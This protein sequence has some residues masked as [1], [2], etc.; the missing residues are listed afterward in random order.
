M[1]STK[2]VF[3]NRMYYYFDDIFKFQ[4]FDFDILLD[5]KPYQD[6]LIYDEGSYS[7]FVYLIW[8]FN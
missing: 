4:D 1:N 3:E 8:V 2:L 5:K 7:S 6:I